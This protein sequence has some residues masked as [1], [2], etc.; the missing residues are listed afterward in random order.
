[1]TDSTILKKVI[2]K[3]GQKIIAKNLGISPSLL[4]K[5]IENR[6]DFKASEIE[7]ISGLL[8]LSPKQ[9]ERIF[10]ARSVDL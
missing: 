3:K 4:E 10:F 8:E 7:G 6:A 1:M 2:Q 5:K 9:R